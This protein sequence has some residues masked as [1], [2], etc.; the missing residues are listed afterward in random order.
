MEASKQAA[1][2]TGKP[3]NYQERKLREEAKKFI[4]TH[5]VPKTPY[6]AWNLARIDADEELAQE[7]NLYLQE[8]GKY[9]KAD[10]ISEYLN[11][12]E[13]KSRWELKK[14]ISRATCKRW[15][16]KLGYRWVKSRH[17]GQYVDGHEREDVIKYRQDV[18]LP[19]WY[20]YESRMRSWDKDGNEIL[21][22]LPPSIQIVVPWFH[23]E[24]IF[25][26]HDRR[27]SQWV[28]NDTSPV[29]YAKG[30]GPSLM[31]AEFFSP[32]YGYCRSRDGK[33][34]ARVFS[35]LEK[36]AMDI[37]TVTTSL[38]KLIPAWIFSKPTTL[39]KNTF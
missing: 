19:I 22:I 9:V 3:T 20:S 18:Y 25:Y 15:M 8:K 2:S 35:S 10:D 29:P 5:N 21:P 12:P 36:I 23:D 38:N 24:S 32:D 30:E 13:V 34:S 7:I 27:E 6:G 26:G 16:K 1:I 14:S 39:M 37:S 4:S 28:Q 33:R 17:R 31:D 11:K